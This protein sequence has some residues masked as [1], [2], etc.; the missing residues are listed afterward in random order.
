M[1]VTAKLVSPGFYRVPATGPTTHIIAQHS[2]G[3]A[4]SSRAAAWSIFEGAVPAGAP[5]HTSTS[6][7]EAKLALGRILEGTR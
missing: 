6:L 5:V 7:R 1:N 3:G 2:H 4:Q